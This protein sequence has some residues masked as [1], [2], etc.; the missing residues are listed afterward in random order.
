[1]LYEC[2]MKRFLEG[3]KLVR[4]ITRSRWMDIQSRQEL[5]VES[6]ER[7]VRNKAPE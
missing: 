6:C 2:C 7:F 1:M 3:P 4:R 5:E